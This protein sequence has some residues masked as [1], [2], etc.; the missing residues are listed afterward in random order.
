MKNIDRIARTAYAGRVNL[1][2]GLGGEL[3]VPLDARGR[4]SAAMPGRS[5]PR[6]L[7]P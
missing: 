4:S 1:L 6:S 3:T 2:D 7:M 5:R